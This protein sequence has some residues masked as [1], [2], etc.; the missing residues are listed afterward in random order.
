MMNLQDGMDKVNNKIKMYKRQ[1]EEAEEVANMNLAKYRKA[2]AE[3]EEAEHRAED[4]ENAFAKLRA[5]SRAQGVSTSRG[6]EVRPKRR[7][8]I[9]EE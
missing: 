6:G 4:A 3:L 8:N 2:Q 1:I 5:I 7:P 9:E